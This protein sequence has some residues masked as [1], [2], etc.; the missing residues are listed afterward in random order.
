MLDTSWN[1]RSWNHEQAS[2]GIPII[3]W[4]Y[5]VRKPNGEVTEVNRFSY[6]LAS[7]VDKT[8]YIQCADQGWIRLDKLTLLTP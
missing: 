8:Q 1:G 7:C 3:E 4:T 6:N 2:R 5:K